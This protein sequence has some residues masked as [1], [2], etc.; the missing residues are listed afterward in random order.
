LKYSELGT[1]I[2]EGQELTVVG[3]SGLTDDVYAEKGMVGEFI[4]IE[5][6]P[7]HGDSVYLLKINWDTYE[8][9]NKD[10]ESDTWYLNAQQDTGTMKEAGEYPKNGIETLYVMGDAEVEI[11]F[12]IGTDS[13]ALLKAKAA[14]KE[15]NP[16]ETFLVWLSNKAGF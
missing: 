15:E 16:K 4:S 7:A 12:M 2:K 14:Y 8:E 3:T 13:E 10:F 5:E 9:I 1:K 11:D 6:E